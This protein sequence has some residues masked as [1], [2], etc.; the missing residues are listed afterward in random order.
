VR[1]VSPN[2]RRFATLVLGIDIVD[3]E[4]REE[5]VP[6]IVAK[7]MKVGIHLPTWVSGEAWIGVSAGR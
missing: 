7:W 3:L 6:L 1:E 4:Q 5:D 2:R